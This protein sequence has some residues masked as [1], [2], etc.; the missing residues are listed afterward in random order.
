MFPHAPIHL[1]TDQLT[2]TYPPILY[3]FLHPVC[4]SVCLS[5][6][7]LVS[8]SVSLLVSL[9]V[10][11]LVYPSVFFTM[12]TYFNLC[13][14]CASSLSDHLDSMNDKLNALEID[15][16]TD[17]LR[18]CAATQWSYIFPKLFY[19]TKIYSNLN[20]AWFSYAADLPAI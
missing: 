12:T 14:R 7:L 16:I 5:V 19:S 15:R 6:C 11:L 20:K 17:H 8:S 1:L 3:L 4:L 9:S 18:Y 10:F 13:L 2:G